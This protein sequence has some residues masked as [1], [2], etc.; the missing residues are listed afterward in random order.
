MGQMIKGNGGLLIG[1]DLKKKSEV[2]KM[3]Y[4]DPHGVTASFNL[5]LLE[6][7][8]KEIGANFC[9]EHFQHEAIY[10]EE[11]NRIEMHLVSVAPQSV[12]VNERNF[13]FE[14]GESIHTENSYKY[15]V[16]EF[17]HLCSLAGFRPKKNWK[18]SHQLFSVHY[19][20]WES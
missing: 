12:R 1:V 20:D 4:D 9:L 19:F 15:S 18:D 8:N 3:A 6:R 2:L 10:N 11:L 13:R 14:E 5:N 17:C 16:E 7:L